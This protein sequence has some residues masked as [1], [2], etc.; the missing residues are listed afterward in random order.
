MK[1]ES[2]IIEILKNKGELQAHEITK[3]ISLT[4]DTTV[5]HLKKMTEE[6]LLVREGRGEEKNENTNRRHW[7][8]YYQLNENYSRE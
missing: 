8:Y 3:L 5:S 6:G 1:T 2:K 7:N 4:Y